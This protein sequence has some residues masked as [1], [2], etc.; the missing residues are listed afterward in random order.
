MVKIILFI[1]VQKVKDAYCNF[2]GN[3]YNTIKQYITKNV[4]E[5]DEIE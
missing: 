1:K 3:H 4:M 2:G 5:I